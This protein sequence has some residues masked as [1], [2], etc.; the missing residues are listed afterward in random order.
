MCT[1][2][3]DVS[4]S[5]ALAAYPNSVELAETTGPGAAVRALRAAAQGTWVIVVDAL[6]LVEIQVLAR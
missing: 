4:A 1:P 5:T 3:I 6:L 2:L